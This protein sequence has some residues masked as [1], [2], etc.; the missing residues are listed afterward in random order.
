MR[1]RGQFVAPG[2]SFTVAGAAIKDM[3]DAGEATMIALTISP[4]NL[5]NYDV[6]EIGGIYVAAQN[7]IIIRESK[8]IY[9]HEQTY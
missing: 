7:A 1:V 9:T 2:M 5:H 6:I 4:S 3:N 8:V